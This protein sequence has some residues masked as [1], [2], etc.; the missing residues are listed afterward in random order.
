MTLVSTAEVRGWSDVDYGDDVIQ[1]VID[2]VE[3]RLAETHEIPT[4]A[5]ADAKLAICMQVARYLKRRKTPEGV[6]QFG[7][8]VA[9]RVNRFDPDIE[10]MLCRFEPARLGLG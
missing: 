2:A 4:P 8:E 1:P 5:P 9:L 6:I 3:A 10:A 7:A